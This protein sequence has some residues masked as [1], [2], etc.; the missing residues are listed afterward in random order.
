MSWRDRNGDLYDEPPPDPHDRCVDGWLGEDTDGRP[1]PC[2][3]C[4]PH[5]RD[6]RC[7]RDQRVT[8]TPLTSGN[9]TS[10]GYPISGSK[11]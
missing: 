11:P 2:L 9:I 5:L 6:R 10:T 1:I 3:R 8:T 7:R 4:R